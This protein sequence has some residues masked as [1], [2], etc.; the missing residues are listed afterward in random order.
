MADP[1]IW[2]IEDGVLAFKVVDTAAVGYLPS[3][4]APAGKTE[5]TVAMADYDTG[6]TRGAARSLPAC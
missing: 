2:Q 4:N 6:W 5:L 3:W 1:F